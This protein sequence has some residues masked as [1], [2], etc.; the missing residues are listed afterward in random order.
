M[1]AFNSSPGGSSS[2]GLSHSRQAAPR[3]P[4]RSIRFRITGSRPTPR[5]RCSWSCSDRSSSAAPNERTLRPELLERFD[6]HGR[7]LVL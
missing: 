7:P 5:G 1:G 6:D 3:M 2:R 4:L